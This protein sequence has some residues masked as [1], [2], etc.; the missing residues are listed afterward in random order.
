MQI[1]PFLSDR[2]YPYAT[3]P[4]QNIPLKKKN[5]KWREAN[6]DALD[7]IA[8]TQFW[9]KQPLLKNYQMVNGELVNEDYLPDGAESEILDLFA[10]KRVETGRYDFRKHKRELQQSLTD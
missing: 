10:E 7:I 8:Q 4:S 3:L 9:Q 6:M 5:K 1:H 2:Q